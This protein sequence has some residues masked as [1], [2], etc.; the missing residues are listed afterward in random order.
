M[1]SISLVHL[2][3]AL[4]R[5]FLLGNPEVHRLG[6]KGGE[7]NLPSTLTGDQTEDVV[8]GE[9]FED[10]SVHSEELDPESLF[11]QVLH[12]LDRE[13]SPR[14]DRGPQLA[15]CH[16]L[17][18]EAGLLP[19]EL[20]PLLAD[21]LR[22]ERGFR[23]PLAALSCEELLRIDDPLK[24]PGEVRGFDRLFGQNDVGEAHVLQ[25]LEESILF[26]LD[27]HKGDLLHRYN[28]G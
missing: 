5:E 12:I 16:E 20:F 1:A 13:V 22:I 8:Q 11:A 21:R 9:G 14:L 18:I 25:A 19:A 10:P 2:G 6:G 17:G 3:K 23:V 15:C 27:P 4:G 28:H 7:A 24:L 26:G